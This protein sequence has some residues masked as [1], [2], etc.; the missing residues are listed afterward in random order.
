[1]ANERFI[2]VCVQVQDDLSK[3]KQSRAEVEKAKRKLEGDYKNSQ[4]S[5]EELTNQKQE[6]EKNIAR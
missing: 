3:E 6:L 2:S 4:N 1:M 5:C